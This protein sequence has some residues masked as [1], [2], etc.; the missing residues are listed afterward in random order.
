MAK[1]FGLGKGLGALIPETEPVPLAAESDGSHEGVLRLPLTALK[2]NPEQPRK[3]FSEEAILQLAES[4]KL[5]GVIQP[6]IAE[7]VGD[8]HYMIVAGE[9]RFR[10]AER[11]GLTEVPVILRSFTPER[12]LEIA[13]IENIQR[14][15]LNPIDEA[16][17]Y[18]SLMEIGNHSQD[19]VADIVGKSRSAVANALRLLRLPETMRAALQD[20]SLSAGH[21]RAIL[22]VTDPSGRERLFARILAEG[23]SVREAETAAQEHNSGGHRRPIRSSG[24]RHPDPEIRRIEDRLIESLGTKVRIKGSSKRGTIAVEYYSLDDLDRILDLL[25]KEPR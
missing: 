4:L 13:L 12:R 8:G 6:I 19:E 3:S 21:A 16:E 22:M 17:A 9:R 7:K 11:A 23:I 18:K 2:A 14:E 1:Q 5:H 20:G 24:E 25:G 10:A 15:D